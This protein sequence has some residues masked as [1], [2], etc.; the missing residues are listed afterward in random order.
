[1]HSASRD[2]TTMTALHG[3]EQGKHDNARP[4]PIPLLRIALL[5]SPEC[6]LPSGRHQGHLCVTTSWQGGG[7]HP[8]PQRWRGLLG[9]N[10]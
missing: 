8:T 4:D 2:P 6:T 1:M 5:L 3:E 7:N 10:Q 9:L